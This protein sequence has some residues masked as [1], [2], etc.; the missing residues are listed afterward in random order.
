M[1]SFILDLK[2]EAKVLF[3]SK[4]YVEAA[5]I[6]STILSNLDGN[7]SP[8]DE[9]MIRDSLI[10]RRLLAILLILSLNHVMFITL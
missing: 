3:K 8:L 2:N 6:N 9:S 4:K 10:Q 1:S 7:H 5:D